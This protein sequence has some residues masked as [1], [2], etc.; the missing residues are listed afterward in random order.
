[1][2]SLSLGTMALAF[3]RAGI[4]TAVRPGVKRWPRNKPGVRGLRQ[5]MASG[6]IVGRSNQHQHVRDA[7]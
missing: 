1:M 6:E 7:R 4:K 5:D 3:H 2:A